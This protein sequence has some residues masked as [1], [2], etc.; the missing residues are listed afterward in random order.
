MEEMMRKFTALLATLIFLVSCSKAGPNE[1][2]DTALNPNVIS[3]PTLSAMY[4]G[5]DPATDGVLSLEIADTEKTCYSLNEGVPIKF[6]FR[7][8]SSEPVTF[9]VFKRDATGFKPI[10]TSRDVYIY[11]DPEAPRDF[12][13][14][15][16]TSLVT[17]LSGE[18]YEDVYGYHLPNSLWI[19]QSPENGAPSTPSV[20]EYLLKFFFENYSDYDA[21]AWKGRIVSN[22]IELCFT[23]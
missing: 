21:H 2:N 3:N 5:P 9:P 17:L 18:S 4:Y 15:T 11:Y 6:T 12:L 1:S 23:E 10:L 8:L 7:N 19:S 22:Q 13:P 20:G 16:M 14:P